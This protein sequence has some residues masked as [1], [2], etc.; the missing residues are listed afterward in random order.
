M[1]YYFIKA[2][3]CNGD[4]QSIYPAGDIIQAESIIDAIEQFKQTHL[5][6]DRQDDVYERYF[7]H[8]TDIKIV[9]IREES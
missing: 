8:I 7:C 2:F 9:D 4:I 6:A 3:I 5:G 1:K